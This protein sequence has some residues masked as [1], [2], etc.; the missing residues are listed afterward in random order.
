MA[1]SKKNASSIIAINRGTGS[2][3]GLSG[4][5]IFLHEVGK[6][7]KGK[8]NYISYVPFKDVITTNIEIGRNVEEADLMDAIVIKVYEELGL[9]ATIDYKITYNEV[10]GTSGDDRI[11]NVFV[12]DG[13]LLNSSFDAI[14]HSVGYVDYV[15]LAPFLFGGLYSRGMLPKEGLDCFI[16]LQKNDA[17]LVIYQNGEY[18]QSRPLRYNLKFINDKFSELTGEKVDDNTFLEMLSKNGVSFPT[19]AERDHIVQIFDDMF[20]YINDVLSGLSKIYNVKIGNIYFGSDIGTIAGTDIFIENTL[21]MAA[22]E[23]NFSVAIN[24]NNF[25]ELTQ[26]DVLMFLT[27]QDYL[28]NSDDAHNYTPF[29]RPPPLSQRPSGKLFGAIGLGLLIGMIIPGYWYGYGYYNQMVGEK[30][31]AEYRELDTKLKRIEDTIKQLETEISKTRELSVAENKVLTKRKNL[32]DGMFDKK[33]NYPMKAMA[34]YDLSNMVNENQGKITRIMDNDKNLTISVQT[35]TDKQMTELL[36][37]ISEARPYA[38]YTRSIT[39]SEDN[40]T[41]A[42]DSN[43]SVEI[44]Q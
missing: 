18:F 26:L 5:E 15:A 20:V 19:P 6:K 7:S 39:L 35:K 10:I 27:L 37:D 23:M 38:V 17:F 41:I 4:N 40:T 8:E 9:D 28:L 44:Q 22:K 21:G 14:A 43:I 16:Y 33:V 1:K 30:T 32:L 36:K 13:Q 24:Q 31:D 42:Y 11:F 2:V 34:I 12:V 25:P 3:F 29:G